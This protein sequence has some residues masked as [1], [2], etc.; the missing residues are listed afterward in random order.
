M[1][2]SLDGSIVYREKKISIQPILIRQIYIFDIPLLEIVQCDQSVLRQL[3]D[4]HGE[5]CHMG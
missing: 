1:D 5:W 3:A 4:Y 2:V